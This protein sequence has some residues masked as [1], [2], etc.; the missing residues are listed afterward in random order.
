MAS[1]Y[2]DYP[3]Q[4]RRNEKTVCAHARTRSE[5]DRIIRQLQKISPKAAFTVHYKGKS[6]AHCTDG[7]RAI[8][9]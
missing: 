4:I 7:G 5:A 1:E 6:I 3:W 9:G 8:D 2:P